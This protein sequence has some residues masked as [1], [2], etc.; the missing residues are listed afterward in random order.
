M[1]AKIVDFFKD[2][3]VAIP[4]VTILGLAIVT[5]A[6]WFFTRSWLI[7]VS[8]ALAL[9][10]IVLI[11]ILLRT[12]L[13]G[14]R[15]ER[16]AG[17][18]ED[19]GAPSPAPGAGSDVRAIFRQAVVEIQRSRM[20]PA[21]I[22]DLPW[23]LTLGST[24]SGKT[25]LVRNAGLDVPGEF[26]HSLRRGP[27]AG[28]NFVLSNQA[29]VVDTAGS[30]VEDADET[31]E[32]WTT[33][34][35]LLA[36][37]R[38]ACPLEGILCVFSALE[39]LE[40]P[41][42]QLEQLARAVR[43][44]RNEAVD[45]LGF[46][47]PLYI[48]VTQIDRLQGF[49]ELAT[50]LPTGRLREA[51]GW[52]ND[53]REISDAAEL[54]RAHLEAAFDPLQR[55]LPELLLREPDRERQRRLYLLPQELEGLV[56]RVGDLL[57]VIFAPSAYRE[58][59][60]LR[61]VY[62]TSAMRDGDA[63]S[64][65]A[66]RLGHPWAA[67]VG[68][69]ASDGGGIFTRDLFGDIIAGDRDIAVPVAGVGRRTRG[70][71]IGLCAAF[72]VACL[73]A[74]GVSF[75]GNWGAI[76]EL[77]SRTQ[78]VLDAPSSIEG[79]NALRE[80]IEAAESS[81]AALAFPA[82]G[83]ARA[84]AVERAKEA[85]L[86][87]MGREHV[88]PSKERLRGVL[89]RSGHDAFEALAV[90]AMDVSWLGTVADEEQAFRPNLVQY[91]V[92]DT[93]DRERAAFN[94]AYDAYV[95]WLPEPTRK[96][97]IKD[98]RDLVLRSATNLLDLR[99]L[100]EWSERQGDRQ[101]PV[102]HADFGV[103]I[104]AQARLAEVPGA[105]T[106]R[107]WESLVRDLLSA[108]E[109]AGGTSEENIA[110][111][112]DGYVKRFDRTWRDFLLSTPTALDPSAAV[113][114]SPHLRI[115]ERLAEEVQVDLPRSA[116]RPAW[117]T[118]IVEL[119]RDDP[120]PKE[121]DAEGQP[122]PA[123]FWTTY[124]Q[125]LDQVA[126]DASRKSPERALEQASKINDG[127]SFIRTIAMLEEQIPPRSETNE[128]RKLRRLLTMPIL[129][130][131]GAV[132]DQAFPEI[133]SRWEAEVADPYSGR[134]SGNDL[135]SLYD[136]NDGV[137]DGFLGDTLGPFLDRDEPRTLLYEL[138][139]PIGSRFFQWLESARTLQD[140]LFPR[141]G[142]APEIAIRLRGI[143]SRVL[144]RSDVFVIRRELR[145]E[146]AESVETLSYTGGT[147]P[148]SMVW[149]PDCQEVSLRMWVRSSGQPDRELKPRK[150]WSG[151]LALPRFFQQATRLGS[152]RLQWDLD[153]EGL[154]VRIEYRMDAGRSILNLAHRAPPARLGENR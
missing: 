69:A 80:G 118:R 121:A 154:D 68:Q 83:S 71:V 37:Q 64:Q 108:V 81:E 132:L 3:R 73:A 113:H 23:W 8:V 119:R 18:L 88:R 31:P 97:R 117:M 85:F 153:Y 44:R 7:A 63:R 128:T 90:L 137:L 105:Y 5:G 70:V 79:A 11:V 143:P 95:R 21:G 130:A 99:R 147:V 123:G 116:R 100:E 135:V 72:A 94:A 30:W 151:P 65:I 2:P 24:S 57:R 110:R 53:R 32:E 107:G 16:L 120:P 89:R 93:N 22:Q 87:A 13:S 92:F 34:L 127:S 82:L 20:G 136:P 109:E 35:K 14:E 4:I 140:A 112:R 46:D 33:L 47:V 134:L 15:E 48:V 51:L 103:K 27:T 41:P 142:G 19:G 6:T 56:D 26:T 145:V 38:P 122:P 17:G 126:T 86:W 129:D 52:T 76:D 91:T 131:G 60:F 149:R 50:S 54:A 104:P 148:M 42:D 133:E 29:V 58:V 10:L 146:C 124:Q 9:A 102:R 40:S 12:L 138:S 74:A 28:C 98:E 152:N 36:K 111:F 139:L 75:V 43:R 59:P 45:T 39:L 61:G 66:Q 101:P 144:N 96:E 49:A 106:R 67:R 25:E 150:S 1:F 114:E 141:A 78:R 62:F 55:L 125:A 77:D 84:R 115:F